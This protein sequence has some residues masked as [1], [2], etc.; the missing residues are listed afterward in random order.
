MR[1]KNNNNEL[2]QKYDEKFIYFVQLWGELLNSKTLDI[3]QHN[4][5]NAF[6]AM[7]ELLKVINNTL[8]GIYTSQY[9]LDDCKNETA[10]LVDNDDILQ[11]I[12]RHMYNSLKNKLH[13]KIDTK[14]SKIALKVQLQ[15]SI[16]AIGDNYIDEILKELKNNLQLNDIEKI[17]KHTKMLVSQCLYNGWSQKALMETTR[18]LNNLA[19]S[20]NEN[21]DNFS[22]K[23]KNT[24]N[25]SHHVYIELKIHTP[26][27]AKKSKVIE[28]LNDM[29][30]QTQNKQEILNKYPEEDL[31]TLIHNEKTYMF[32]EA[33]APD[34]YSAAVQALQIISNKIYLLSFYRIMDFWNIADSTIFVINP[35]SKYKKS[36]NADSLFNPY[37]Y[38]DITNRVFEKT[39]T[40]F[41][42]SN[43]NIIEK[44]SGAFAYTNISRAS[45]FQEA[46][47]INLWVA[48]ESLVRTDLYR[49]II[50]NLKEVVPAACT[51]RYIFSIIRNFIEDCDRCEILFDFSSINIDIEQKQNAVEKMLIIMKDSTLYAELQNKAI[52]NTLLFE[53]CKE[54]HTLVTE[55][56]VLQYKL[57]NH[58]KMVKWQLQRLYRI[59][60]G[61]AHS[62]NNFNLSTMHIR[63]LFSYLTTTI[64]EIVAIACKN[65]FKTIDEICCKIVDD[66][67]CAIELLK[68]SR[69]NNTIEETVLK[70]GFIDLI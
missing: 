11:S 70:T 5:L 36:F 33:T 31:S 3:Y 32:I 68:N 38:I 62:A 69:T 55:H 4:L 66:Y 25:I 63:H 39:K 41:S 22:N 60:N 6:L 8:S 37:E 54:I 30:C 61:I 51:K 52:V 7:K 46:K 65:E 48:L 56:K 15:S 45:M 57:E 50:T 58:Y 28:E 44:L 21:W 59:R 49:D 9:N 14:E 10:Y 40:I 1:K 23:L 35:V 12:N 18:F 27:P 16:R 20:F 64:L 17:T 13:A 24:S 2:N 19:G 47:F 42:S 29:G 53:R 43:N 34:V 67:R 26:S